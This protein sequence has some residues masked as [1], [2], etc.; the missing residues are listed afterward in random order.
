[1]TVTIKG[2]FLN[3]IAYVP[4]GWHLVDSSFLSTGGFTFTGTPTYYSF[5]DFNELKL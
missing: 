2:T 4:S 5:V 3:Q 1:M